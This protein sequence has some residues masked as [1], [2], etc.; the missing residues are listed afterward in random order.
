MP[1]PSDPPALLPAVFCTQQVSP[2]PQTHYLNLLS[3]DS[4]SFLTLLSRAGR[5]GNVA[6]IAELACSSPFDRAAAGRRQLPLSSP[7]VA[8]SLTAE[9]GDFSNLCRKQSHFLQLTIFFLSDS[10][11]PFLHLSAGSNACLACTPTYIHIIPTAW[12][13]LIN[14]G[15]N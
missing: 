4:M 7:E 12:H 8:T 14:S 15:Q 1:L 6:G 3:S 11:V 2:L 10:P 9:L 13:E 5:V